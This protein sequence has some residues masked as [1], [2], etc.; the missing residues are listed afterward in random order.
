MKQWLVVVAVLAACKPKEVPFKPPPKDDAAAAALDAA[1]EIDAALARED[2]RAT[3]IVVGDHASCALLTD[4]TV[5]CWGRNAD[6]QLGNNSTN[7]ASTPVKVGLRGVKDIVLGAAHACALLDDESVTCWGKINYGSKDPLLAPAAASGVA[8]AKR[9]FAVGAASC[10]TLAD[11]SLVCWGDIDAKGRWKLS[12]SGATRPPTPT[13]GLDSVVAVTANGALREDGTVWLRDGEGRFVRTGLTNVIEIA[14]SGEEVCALRRDGSVACVGPSTRC[15]A[16]APKLTKPAPA[17]KT[18]AKKTKAGSKT[19]QTA[20]KPTKPAPTVAAPTLPIEVLRLPR[21]QHLAFDVGLCVVTKPGRLQCL[22]PNDGCR[23]E[24]AW[25][26]LASIDYVVGN[27]ARITN[28]DARCWS[29]DVKT[30]TVTAVAGVADAIAVAASGSHACAILG[31]R[32]VVCWGSNKFGALGRG[33][34]DVQRDR[35]ARPVTF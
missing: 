10:A 31:D 4:A 3:K 22:A 25:P 7:D 17:K 20:T 1:Q 6:G 5:R 30:R 26:G 19:K 18:A 2:V 21:A 29:A 24:T 34:S 11:T 27:C 35:E 33:N 16:A 28:G 23:V 14:S 32:S 15:A 12:R 8:K 13:D 9:I